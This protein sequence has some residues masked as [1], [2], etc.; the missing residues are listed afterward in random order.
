MKKRTKDSFSSISKKKMDYKWIIFGLLFSC[1][2]SRYF[3]EY[4]RI[5]FYGFTWILFGCMLFY[6][7]VHIRP[8]QDIQKRNWLIFYSVVF[9]AGMITGYHI[10][11]NFNLYNG[12]RLENYITEYSFKD[13]WVFF[14]LILVS[15]LIF[16]A[17][18]Q[19]FGFCASQIQLTIQTGI[20]NKKKWILVSGILLLLWTPYL[21]TYYPGIILGDSIG[22]IHQAI[23]TASWNNHHP[24]LYTFFI[25]ICLNI[26]TFI[27]DVTFGCCIYTVIQMVYIALCLGYF[28]CWLWN[29]GMPI[30]A[31]WVMVA[32]YGLSPF[33]ACNSIAMWKD[34]IFSATICVWTLVIFDFVLSEGA[35][36]NRNFLIKN[37][38][39]IFAVCFVRNNGI[40]IVCFLELS[41]LLTVF[42]KRKGS[43]FPKLKKVA[44]NMGIIVFTIYIITGP[45]YQNLNLNGEPVESL[46]IFLNQMASVVSYNGNMS[47]FD[48]EFMEHLLP[49]DRYEDTYRPCV[50]DLLKWDDEFSQDYLNTHIDDFWKTYFSMLVKNPRLYIE[51]WELNTFGYWAVNYWELNFDRENIKKG[52]LGDIISSWG[53]STGIVPDNLLDTVLK[54]SEDI[55]PLND[56]SIA[57]AVISWLIL[58][59]YIIVFIKGNLYINLALAPS[60]GLILTLL[61]G[62]P[63]AYWQR[64]GLAMYYLIPFYIFTPLYKFL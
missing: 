6:L 13:L 18:I 49:L 17:L 46:G 36:F 28:I 37:L 43:L 48:R 3:L 15:L 20:F 61:I 47:D 44:A 59:C 41:L 23:G 9:S 33:F 25:S 11:T 64:Y 24:L 29:K 31:G 5:P 4:M 27:K 57:L 14:I 12:T 42:I 32:F 55:F 39:M 45:I 54:N 30:K 19:L 58:F 56:A 50:V 38:W 60:A 16:Q 1:F 8:C 63:Y 51:A 26:G 53:T 2:G 7:F 21:L 10:K 34:P 62:T 52:N 35:V 40:Y 22:S